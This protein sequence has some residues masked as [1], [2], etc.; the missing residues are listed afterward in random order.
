[1]SEVYAA[2][3]LKSFYVPIKKVLISSWQ[4][5]ERNVDMTEYTEAYKKYRYDMIVFCISGRT[6]N[7]RYDKETY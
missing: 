3:D 4:S 5:E 2:I 7:V 6:C 1:M